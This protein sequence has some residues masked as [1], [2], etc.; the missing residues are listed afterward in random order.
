M[1]ISVSAFPPEFLDLLIQASKQRIKFTM[2]YN[3]AVSRR[4]WLYRLRAA[5]KRE[6]HYAYNTCA[7]VVIRIHPD[8]PLKKTDIVELTLEPRDTDFAAVIASQLGDLRPQEEKQEASTNDIPT[9]DPPE[10]EVE[11]DL[12][13]MFTKDGEDEE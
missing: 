3:E 11:T 13:S 1:A 6:N 10:D 8:K 9:E 4:Q 5:M 12:F 2:P 7:L